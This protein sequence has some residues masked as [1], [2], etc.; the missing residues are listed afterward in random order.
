MLQ[1]W[2]VLCWSTTS[3]SIQL[4][5]QHI[6]RLLGDKYQNL[7]RLGCPITFAVDKQPGKHREID[8]EG[9]ECFFL[10]VNS[11]QC[12]FFCLSPIFNIKF[13]L[14]REETLSMPLQA[15]IT[16]F[17]HLQITGNQL[18]NIKIT[19]NQDINLVLLRYHNIRSPLRIKD[20]WQ[21]SILLS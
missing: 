18:S 4:A 10:K 20:G 21:S 3:K 14:L 1:S 11:H 19:K 6:R 7:M 15:T 17:S 16:F 2:I 5:S 8:G 9:G 13:G 12:A